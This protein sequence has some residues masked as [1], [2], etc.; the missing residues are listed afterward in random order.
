MAEAL[1]LTKTIHAPRP[2]FS[3]AI[4][5]ISSEHRD[6]LLAH[7]RI[8]Y[9]VE[10]AEA[11]LPELE[12]ILK[13]YYAHK[14][15]EMIRGELHFDPRE[16]FTESDTILITYGDIFHGGEGLPI[17]QMA[18][19][20]EAFDFRL[21]LGM[22]EGLTIN[23]MAETLE[24]YNE[25]ITSVHILPFYPSSSDRGFSVVDFYSVDPSLG[26]WQDIGRL[27]TRFQLMF[28]G[29]INHV[30]SQHAWFREFLNG[31]PKFQDYFISFRSSE[32]LTLEDRG[33]LFR[34]R[35][36]DILTRFET[37]NGPRYV[38]TTFSHDQVDLNYKNPEVLLSVVELLLFYVRQ[39]ADIIRLDAVTYLWAE[40]GTSSVHLEQT[41]EIVKLF[42]TILGIVA[43]HVALVTETNV[44]HEENVSY[45]GDGSDE[46]QMIYNFALPP[47]VLHTFYQED[48]T[49]I[50][51]WAE[52]LLSPSDTTTFFNVLD[53]HDGVGLMGVQGILQK[54]EIEKMTERAKELGAFISFKTAKN[55]TEEPYEINS[56]WWSALNPEG[57]DEDLPLQVSRFIASRSLSLTL[58]GVPGIYV[59][60]LL[61]TENRPEVVRETGSKRDI[62]RLPIHRGTIAKDLGNPESKLS[63]IAD[64]LSKILLLRTHQRAF[65]PHGPRRILTISKQV[66]SI[67]R[68]SPEGDQHIL[69]MTNISKEQAEA[70]FA[71]SE[72]GVQELEWHDLIRGGRYRADEGMLRVAMAPYQIVWMKPLS[73]LA[74]G[75]H[76]F[77]ERLT[78]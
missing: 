78:E 55:G 1:P 65:H 36:S 48:V 15:P 23:Q 71:I 19:T 8:L 37:L 46:A 29:V 56:T 6:R 34:P 73:E 12:R 35:T 47:L 60:G 40:P 33:K 16:R 69:A 22:G 11:S 31:N 20:L 21:I 13:V 75:D 70:V 42:R 39:G 74:N 14:Q 77:E 24:T 25:I 43:P 28:D 3:R 67:L 32:E 41:H 18:E 44:P 9:G 30:S 68:T 45:F 4:L 76:S 59:H 10:L 27:E 26:N 5:K 49:A 2:D 58:P 54:E 53:T 63:L 66:F 50:S 62:N 57:S 61:G 52:N 64:G 72:L 17:N 7:L 38:W 51:N